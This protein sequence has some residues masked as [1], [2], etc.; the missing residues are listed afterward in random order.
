MKEKQ[1]KPLKILNGTFE[2]LLRGSSG[3]KQRVVCLHEIY[4]DII[5]Y[6]L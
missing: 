1:I 6:N 5:I 4:C 3:V 2:I